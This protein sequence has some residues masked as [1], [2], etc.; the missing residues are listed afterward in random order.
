MY[1]CIIEGVPHPGGLLSGAYGAADQ[2]QVCITSIYIYTYIDLCIDIYTYIDLCI[3]VYT[4]IDLCIDIYT[5][6]YQW[7]KTAET[8]S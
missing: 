6:I 7:Q 8:Q 4:Y 3:Y 5:H 2:W 1:T